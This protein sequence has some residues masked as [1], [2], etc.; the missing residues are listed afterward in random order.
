MVDEDMRMGHGQ[1]RPGCE[2]CEQERLETESLSNSPEK[3][4]AVIGSTVRDWYRCK[5]SLRLTSGE[6]VR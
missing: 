3:R 5:A 1:G 6:P 4:R 2:D